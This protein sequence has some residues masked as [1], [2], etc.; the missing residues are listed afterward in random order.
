MLGDTI[1]AIATAPGS[2]AIAVIRVSGEDTFKIVEKIFRPRTKG[3]KLSQQKGYTIHFGEIVDGDEV[4]DEVL[5]S[6]FRAPHSYTGEDSVEISCHGSLYIQQ[7]I[8]ELLVNAGARVARPGEFTMRAYLNNK[9]DL[10]QAEAVADLIAA[11]SEAARRVAF[12]QL[13]GG[14]SRELRDLRQRLVDFASLIELELDFAEEDVEFADRSQLRELILQIKQ[15]TEKLLSTFRYGNAIK[16]GIP[17]AI[18]GEPNVGK[19]TL[20]NLLLKEDRAIVSDIPGTTRDTIEDVITING[21]LF[22]FI[23]T[24]GLRHT[25]DQIE[26]LGI[27]RTKQMIRKAQ[28]VLFMIDA[29]D[30]DWRQ[31]LTQIQEHITDQRVVIVVNKIDLIDKPSDFDTADY[32]VVFLSAKYHKNIEQ[33]EQTLLEAIGYS[34]HAQDEV[35][36][37]N[38]RHYE[39]LRRAHEAIERVIEGLDTGLSNDLL[40]EDVRQVMYYLGDITGEITADEVLGNIF[41]RFCIGK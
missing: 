17:V 1:T 28:I 3:K 14:V 21:I 12:S 16:S 15:R 8:I 18:V 27:E 31:K 23:D 40:A 2:G 39:A 38:A 35:I 29:R 41:S 26:A 34:Q 6:V 24:A 37:T 22:R 9:M 4:I 5:V 20:L 10:A 36:L 19:S 13:R 25:R 32:P 11:T 30:K 7:K 33:L